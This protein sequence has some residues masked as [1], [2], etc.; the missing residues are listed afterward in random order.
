MSGSKLFVA[1]LATAISAPFSTS[2][3][4]NP[5]STPKVHAH[6]ATGKTTGTHMT[7]P[8]AGQ[9]STGQNATGHH[10]THNGAIQALHQAHTLLANANH[11]YDGHRA[12]AAHLVTQAI[13]EL[14][15][16]HHHTNTTGVTHRGTTAQGAA[17]VNLG[18]GKN[19][20][21]N[22]G[23]A[24][25]GGV[26]LGGAKNA[27]GKFGGVNLGAAQN[28][29]AKLGGGNNV[30][31]VN[32][33]GGNNGAAGKG[34]GMR[35]PQAQSDAQLRQAMQLLNGVHGQLGNN[36]KASTHIQSAITELN[37]ALRIR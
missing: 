29:G 24:N 19:G 5:G 3:S 17:G 20:G 25:L 11:D 22:N 23:A 34:N 2:S 35:E 10:T 9:N 33:G 21:V 36:H 6:T 16:T 15:G 26:N 14:S 30:A 28:G 27:G 7:G 12:K 4:A 32:N 8:H 37:T 18:A 31:A 1:V 13:H